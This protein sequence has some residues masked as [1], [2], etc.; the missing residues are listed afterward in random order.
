MPLFPEDFGISCTWRYRARWRFNPPKN[1][2][3]EDEQKSHKRH[4]KGHKTKTTETHN[5]NDVNASV[6]GCLSGFCNQSGT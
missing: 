1:F 3:D 5:A 6:N 2:K 4:E